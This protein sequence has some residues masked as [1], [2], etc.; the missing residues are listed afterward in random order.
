MMRQINVLLVDDDP[1]FHFINTKMLQ[2][3]GVTRIYTAPNGK[4]ALEFIESA[5]KESMPDII[6][7]DLQMPILNGFGFIEAFRNLN[8]PHKEQIRIVIL[9][10]SFSP[11]DKLRAQELGVTDYLIKPL[12]ETSIRPVLESLPASHRL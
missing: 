4:E 10:S 11:R 12:S 9:T 1:L 6:L 7:V 8:I 5:E 3:E 2:F